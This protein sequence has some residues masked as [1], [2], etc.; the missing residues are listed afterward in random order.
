[1]EL[2]ISEYYSLVIIIILINILFWFLN[3]IKKL[4]FILKF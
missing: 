2:H 1:M 3:F 4:F